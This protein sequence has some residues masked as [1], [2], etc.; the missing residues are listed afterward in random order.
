[1]EL[2]NIENV[3]LA[4]NTKTTELVSKL[5]YGP[6]YTNTLCI[7]MGLHVQYNKSSLI[8]YGE[9]SFIVY[10][11]LT[12][13]EYAKQG[14]DYEALNMT[15]TDLKR[16]FI[17]RDDIDVGQE[18]D[19]LLLKNICSGVQANLDMDIGAAVDCFFEKPLM[20]YA[21]GDW[22]DRGWGHTCN[23]YLVG[24]KIKRYR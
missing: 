17:N 8:S 22:I 18:Y 3:I 20:F 9:K 12:Y 11:Y 15:F 10:L 6:Q 16:N 21:Q 5:N 13:W 14:N 23:Q 2:G 1:M 19:N 7:N 4:Y 24:V